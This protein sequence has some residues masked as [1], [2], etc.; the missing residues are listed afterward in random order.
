MVGILGFEV[1]LALAVALGLA[2]YWLTR[3]ARALRPAFAN[4]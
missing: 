3:G 1:N 4:R 2:L